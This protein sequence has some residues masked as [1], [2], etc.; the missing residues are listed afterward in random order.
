MTYAYRPDGMRQ[1]KAGTDGTTTHLWDGV[2]IVGDVSAEGTT[3]YVRGINLAY[4]MDG[5]GE[6]QFYLYNAHGDVV[7]LADI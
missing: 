2:N 1:S 7:Q 4:S 6:K 3:L 5:A